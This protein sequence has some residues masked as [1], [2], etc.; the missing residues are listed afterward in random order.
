MKIIH[1]D[2][3]G[4]SGGGGEAGNGLGQ[5]VG[6]VFFSYNFTFGND[7]IADITNQAFR[8][9]NEDYPD[10]FTT[11]QLP[12]TL[13]GLPV[14]LELNNSNLPYPLYTH[15]FDDHFWI[16]GRNLFGGSNGVRLSKVMKGDW[17]IE[18]HD[19]DL[20][21]SNFYS[22][23]IFDGSE[24]FLIYIE[25][26]GASK[27][28]TEAKKFNVNTK[29]TTTLT[30]NPKRIVKAYFDDLLQKFVVFEVNATDDNDSD[31]SKNGIYYYDNFDDVKTVADVPLTRFDWGTNQITG[32]VSLFKYSTLRKKD[33][34]ILY[35]DKTTKELKDHTTNAVITP[36]VGQDGTTAGIT[37]FTSI[38]ELYGRV[39]FSFGD[40]KDATNYLALGC[41]KDGEDT[42]YAYPYDLVAS[43]VFLI[44]DKIFDYD[45]DS[46]TGPSAPAVL[47]TTSA[48]KRRGLTF[49]SVKEKQY[50]FDDVNSV[51]PPSS[52]TFIDYSY[53]VDDYRNVYG[54]SDEDLSY[55]IYDQYGFIQSLTYA[56]IDLKFNGFGVPD[57]YIP[58]LAVGNLITYLIVKK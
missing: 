41:Y 4:G 44:Y 33:G 42:R 24:N 20:G 40:V 25:A 29:I 5:A 3:A 1:N 8:G 58:P 34:Q 11:I 7:K 9:K 56:V 26:N 28:I 18:V 14:T 22:K 16:V 17:Q 32:L 15:E 10:L 31:M 53:M 43:G 54:K 2:Q 39:F 51:N 50:V 48:Q 13:A 36:I 23:I 55:R 38:F 37:G 6:D 30:L 46:P 52:V 19:I 21:V 35:I 47:Y 12:P 27:K 49:N 45:F 57:I